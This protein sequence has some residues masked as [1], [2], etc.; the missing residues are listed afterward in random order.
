MVS[1]RAQ[2]HE[3]QGQGGRRRGA[4]V[5]GRA[6][7]GHPV[8]HQARAQSAVKRPPTSGASQSVPRRFITSYNESRPVR[9]TPSSTTLS[10]TKRFKHAT[11]VQHV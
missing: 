7:G 8:R 2:S 5:R 11:Q 1:G 10:H 3:P 4:Q 6:R 9:Q